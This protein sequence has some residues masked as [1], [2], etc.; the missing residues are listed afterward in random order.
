MYKPLAVFASLASLGL[1]YACSLNTTAAGTS[2]PSTGGASSA[3][4]DQCKQ[5]CD[6]MKFFACNSAE[7]QA[8][9][10]AD[11]G[12]AT[13]DQIQL[14]DA[15]AENSVC[16]PACRTNIVPKPA[17]GGAV[18]GTGATPATCGTACSKLVSCSFVKVGDEKACESQ[19]AS[20]A[21]QY[22]IDC[23]NGTECGNIQKACGGGE[24]GSSTGGNV[25]GGDLTITEC[26]QACDQLLFFRCITADD[27]S[28]CRVA[29]TTTTSAK[30]STFV[31]CANAAG[32]ECPNA[33]ACYTTF[34]K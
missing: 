23:I 30:R 28:T 33:T 16:D 26:Q 3:Q 31:S 29:C 8:A 13:A 20:E 4:V 6:K 9:C 5:S 11:C 10:Y 27:Q 2:P 14:F 19:C 34:H 17:G 7:E 1:L 12:K 32:G 24:T 25:D 22:Q 21:Y 18:K 15:C